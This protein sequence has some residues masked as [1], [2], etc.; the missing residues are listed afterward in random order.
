MSDALDRRDRLAPYSGKRGSMVLV[1]QGR[2]AL[3]P[4]SSE[5][6]DAGHPGGIAR[7][8]VLDAPVQDTPLML[9]NDA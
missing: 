4:L 6:C 3:G 5:G 2:Q 8:V 1:T 9:L 7:G